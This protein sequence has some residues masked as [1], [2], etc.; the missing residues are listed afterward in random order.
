MFILPSTLEAQYRTNWVANC[1]NHA[2]MTGTN[3]LTLFLPT[4]H[5]DLDCRIDRNVPIT[6]CCIR[7]LHSFTGSTAAVG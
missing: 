4:V 3:T 7:A 2:L 6:V 5:A 1:C